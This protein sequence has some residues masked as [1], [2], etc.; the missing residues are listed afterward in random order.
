MKV[1][2][3][4]TL[5]MEDFYAP[6]SLPEVKVEAAPPPPPAEMPEAKVEGSAVTKPARK[7]AAAKKK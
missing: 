2:P 6:E 7:R 3:D 4:N 1:N 5:D